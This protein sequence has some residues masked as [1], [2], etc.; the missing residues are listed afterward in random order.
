[1]KGFVLDASLTLAWLFEDE[2]D[3]GADA[4][5][6]EL[7]EGNGFAPTTWSLETAQGILRAERL[8]RID[9]PTALALSRQLVA[10]EL[11]L[12]PIGAEDA[13]RDIIAVA[14][15]HQVSVYDASYLH[16]ALVTALPLATRDRAQADAA[17]AAGVRLLS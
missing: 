13:H 11:T 3:D 17:A 14:R 4:L 6:D 7:V 15:R 1:M 5:L 10:L 9:R 12:V 16:V 2:S 8:R